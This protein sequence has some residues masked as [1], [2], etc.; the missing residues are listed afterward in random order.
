MHR[1]STLACILFMTLAAEYCIIYLLNKYPALEN[2]SS[3]PPPLFL[4]SLLISI[5]IFSFENKKKNFY[6]FILELSNSVIN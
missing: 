1:D 5:R 6:L 4:Y 3:P 2:N